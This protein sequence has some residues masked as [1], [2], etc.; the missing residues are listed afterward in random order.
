MIIITNNQPGFVKKQDNNNGD[1]VNGA[2]RF[3][4]V[5]LIGPNGEQFGEM[6]SREAQFKANELDLDLLCV[7]RPKEG[8]TALP[9]CKL[10]NYGK[11]RYEQQKKA[12]AAKK[13]QHVVE[14]KEIQ[15]T[16]QIGIHD[17]EVKSK[18]AIGFLKD[19]NK[20]KIGVRFR[21]RQMAHQEV[22]MDVINKFIE[23]LR[24]FATIEKQPVMDGRWLNAVVGPKK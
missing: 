23:S 24:E 6:S 11:Y 5:L 16:P 17:L 7:S 9:V 10:V 3:P 21:G 2:I 4:K 19:G 12:K 22:G 1:L 14:V 15:L 8:S 18:A 13:N 20:V